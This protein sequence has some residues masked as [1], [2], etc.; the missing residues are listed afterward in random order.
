MESD[1]G[2]LT[3]PMALLVLQ[4][5]SAPLQ[6]RLNALRFLAAFLRPGGDRTPSPPS[7]DETT[8][9]NI[10]KILFDSLLEMVMGE[11][12]SADLR[13]R[14]LIRTE[15]FIMLAN[16][17]KSQT[18]FGDAY[19]KIQL[20]EL[21][22]KLGPMGESEHG[23]GMDSEEQPTSVES[24]SPT[25]AVPRAHSTTSSEFLD[26]DH[27]KGRGPP[28]LSQ[29]ASVVSV[30]AS[31]AERS[32][33]RQS[34]GTRQRGASR[35]QRHVVMDALQAKYHKSKVAHMREKKGLKPRQG[36]IFGS[37]YDK[38]HFIPGADPSNWTEQDR[39]LGYR[40]ER[41]WFPFSVGLNSSIIPAAREQNNPHAIEPEQIVQEYQQMKA[42]MS[43]VGDLVMVPPGPGGAAPV[44]GQ[45]R[46]AGKSP[47]PLEKGRYDM[48]VREAVQMWTP[49][50]GAN[51]PAHA[52]RLLMPKADAAPPA[53]GTVS[54]TK[55]GKPAGPTQPP[56]EVPRIT[57]STAQ[58]KMA[59]MYDAPARAPHQAESSVL[60][61]KRVLKELRA[62]E[63]A[64]NRQTKASIRG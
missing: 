5:P 24:A 54:R 34:M 52:R 6:D 39:R 12:R 36:I 18:L 11:D 28:A 42:L 33:T 57:P 44:P 29:S 31:V 46:E 14:Q 13:K 30:D 4:T 47:S 26:P 48:A 25:R 59:S 8:R 3:L 50:L 41:M 22:G 62:M 27:G 16:V 7:M 9:A 51:L 15:C 40:K 49:I 45:A 20:S 64:G 37:S 1:P 63:V 38:E 35:R 53:P 55:P 60:V 17:L 19:A 21:F 2:A 23:V 58:R 56:K 61:T 43:Y 10:N 32:P